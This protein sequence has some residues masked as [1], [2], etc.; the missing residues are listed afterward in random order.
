MRCPFVCA[1]RRRCELWPGR[2]F[3][4][5]DLGHLSTT[6]SGKWANHGSEIILALRLASGARLESGRSTGGSTTIRL[7]P[8]VASIPFAP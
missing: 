2:K 1:G 5:N 8:C 6:R 4:A 3:A 7:C